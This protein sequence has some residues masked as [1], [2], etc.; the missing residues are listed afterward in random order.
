MTVD[1]KAADLIRRRMARKSAFGHSQA[2]ARMRSAQLLVDVYPPAARLRSGLRCIAP[3]RGAVM[4][5]LDPYRDLGVQR[6][7]PGD[8]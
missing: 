3:A 4:A 7:Q 2:G 5:V 6:R 1:G 8:G